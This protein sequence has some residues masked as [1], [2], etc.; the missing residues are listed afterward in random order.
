[1]LTGISCLNWILNV[2]HAV[3]TDRGSRLQQGFMSLPSFCQKCQ[4]MWPPVT[5]YRTYTRGN[6]LLQQC[7]WYHINRWLQCIFSSGY[8]PHGLTIKQ[9][10]LLWHGAIFTV[11]VMVKCISKMPISVV[12]YT[13]NHQ[14]QKKRI[15][16]AEIQ[17]PSLWCPQHPKTPVNRTI[18]ILHI[19]MLL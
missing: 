6:R 13:C 11:Y 14:M 8:E 4:P 15:I 9:W 17:S 10:L 3:N 7:W 18:D 19:R 16:A 5:K 2:F 1:M 12:N